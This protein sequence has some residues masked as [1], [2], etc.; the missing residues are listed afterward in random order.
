MTKIVVLAMVA[1]WAA[2]L[3]PPL[4]RS[5]VDNR[6]NSSVHD[7]R[8][9]LATLQRT[10]PTQRVAPMRAMARPLAQSGH[11]RATARVAR[12]HDGSLGAAVGQHAAR[13]LTGLT[14]GGAGSRS[15]TGSNRRPAAQR[16]HER[17]RIERRAAAPVSQREMIRRRRTNV[18]LLLVATTCVTGF[19]AATTKSSAMVFGFGVA[20]V[21]LLVFCYKLVQLRAA[22]SG[23]DSYRYRTA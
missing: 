18:L 5:R 21:A 9:H 20:L 22:E 4:L 7:F 8:R 15:H 13:Q 23:D 3:I 2:V 16:S 12:A 14:A 1:A 10:V 6:P 17:S 11:A 19:L